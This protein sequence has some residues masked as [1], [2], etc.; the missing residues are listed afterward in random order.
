[1]PRWSDRQHAFAAALLDPGRPAPE[2]LPGAG[3]ESP[4]SR[5]AV[6]RNNV[7]V[8]LTEALRAGFPCT[9]RL[10]GTEFFAAL[11]R[12]FVAAHPPDSPVLLSYGAGFAD[13]LASFP[14]AANLPYLADV[15]RIERAA[16]EA[17]HARDEPA[18]SADAL[19]LV[20]P[21][22][23]PFLRLRLHPSLRLLR[24][25]FPAFT[26]WRMNAADGAPGPVDLSD[27][28]NTL[29]LRPDAEVDV[30]P[31]SN[32]AHD[33]IAALARGRTLAQAAARA[34]AA[35]AGFDLSAHL[36]QS[37]AMG[38]WVGFESAQAGNDDD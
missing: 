16:T 25:S 8:G 13:F 36:R 34:L 27:A 2:G 20:P 4:A 14:P 1:M 30:R 9:A 19:A 3:R 38:A 23:A 28:Q 6:H 35:D 37:I 33:F 31:V 22:R 18:L 10:V 11:A 7:F 17:Y 26:I 21:E 12:V 32:A 24:S 29:I 15:A 5:F